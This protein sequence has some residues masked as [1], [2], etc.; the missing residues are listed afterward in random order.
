VIQTAHR[1]A[2]RL[3]AATDAVWLKRSITQ[4]MP[5]RPHTLEAT[6]QVGD[7]GLSAIEGRFHEF[8]WRCRF[9]GERRRQKLS[10]RNIECET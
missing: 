4:S 2:L 1:R 8:V 7:H 3:V 6:A 5:N 10:Y 9:C